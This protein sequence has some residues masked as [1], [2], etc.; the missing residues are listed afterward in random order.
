[1]NVINLTPHDVTVWLDDD[2]LGGKVRFPASGQ[3]ARLGT[4]ELGT[5]SYPGVLAPV[6]LVEFHHLE[7]PPPQEDGT[8]YIVS[9]PT[10]LA[11]PRK[12]FLVPY[13]EVRDE[14]GRIVGCRM[15]ARP[16]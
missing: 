13:R 14:D 4:I 9:L 2:P 8:W 5:Q 3:V 11:H 1:M 6:E 10:A 15:L 16:V 12:D 7:N